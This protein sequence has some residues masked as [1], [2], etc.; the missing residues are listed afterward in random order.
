MK[1]TLTQVLVLVVLMIIRFDKNY[2]SGGGPV[3]DSAGWMVTGRGDGDF[4]GTVL[5]PF[6]YSF[7]NF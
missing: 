6:F 7:E 5:P 4:L 3:G 1:L 2:K